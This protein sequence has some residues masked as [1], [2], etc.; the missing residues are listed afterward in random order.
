ML[1]LLAATALAASPTWF[2]PGPGLERAWIGADGTLVSRPGDTGGLPARPVGTVLARAAD[3]AA[4]GRIAGVA[5][6]VPLRGDGRTV[7]LELDAGADPFALS[8]ELHARADV[9]WA[10]PDLFVPL[11]PH[12]LPD[13]PYLGS[14]WHLDNPGS[15]SSAAGVDVRAVDAWQITTG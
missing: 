9:R 4:L 3:P 8:R 7:R 5:A 13:D 11:Q 10:H 1:A 6:V 2:F 14:Q 12:D 15:E